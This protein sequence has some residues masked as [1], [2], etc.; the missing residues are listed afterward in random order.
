MRGGGPR[1]VQGRGLWNPRSEPLGVSER[2]V[3][4]ECDNTATG[5]QPTRGSFRLYTPAA[6]GQ[7]RGTNGGGESQAASRGG[8]HDATLDEAPNTLVRGG[9]LAHLRRL[10]AGRDDRETSGWLRSWEKPISEVT[11][12]DGRQLVE[13][14]VPEGRCLDYR[15]ELYEPTPKGFREF[16]S[17]V[18]ACGEHGRGLVVL[19]VS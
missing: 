17:H 13:A 14:R 2:W 15:A 18:A 3:R 10:R 19:G 1:D 7:A 16:A 8:D 6:E 4:P 9:W 5:Q 12:Q 11:L